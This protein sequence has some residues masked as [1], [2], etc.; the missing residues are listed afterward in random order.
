MPAEQRRVAPDGPVQIFF[1]N[2]LVAMVCRLE[3]DMNKPISA[4]HEQA[5]E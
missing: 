3:P 4:D 1:P 2:P 5:C